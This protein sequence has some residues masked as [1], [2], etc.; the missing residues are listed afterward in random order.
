[1]LLRGSQKPESDIDLFVVS[2]NASRNYFNGWLDIYEVNRIEF[3]DWAKKLDISVTD[4][5]FSGNLIYGNKSYFEKVKRKIKN[6]PITQEAIIHH[7]SEIERLK[8]Y[9]TNISHE[10]DSRKKY[11]VSF[12]QNLEQLLLGNKPLTLKNLKEI[13]S[14]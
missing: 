6:Q 14:K 9:K 1:M 11:I 3:N 5:I 13:Y 2:N 12:S 4:P 8:K 10:E 7:L